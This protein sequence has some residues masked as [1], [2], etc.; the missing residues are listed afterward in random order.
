MIR[1]AELF[2]THRTTFLKVKKTP[3]YIERGR[4]SNVQTIMCRQ[5]VSSGFAAS[6]QA[7]T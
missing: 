3:G 4:L 2:L 7:L 1:L 6:A 5:C